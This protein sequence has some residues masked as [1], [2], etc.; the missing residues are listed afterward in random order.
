MEFK[1]LGLPKEILKAVT[2]LGFESPSE[3]QEKA[4]P[5]LSE[6]KQD[7]VGLAQTGTG[8][9]A[10]F[11]LPLIQH[12]NFDDRTTQALIICP[13][14][15]LCMQITRDLDSFAIYQNNPN[16]TSVYG[17]ANI[18]DQIRKLKK[19]AQII[20]ATPGRLLDLINRKAVKLKSVERLVLDEADEMLNMGFKEDI[21]AI[22]DQT[23]AAKRVWLFSATM[24]KAVKRIAKNYMHDPVEIVVGEQNSVAANIEHRYYMMKE[25]DRYHAI[26]RI[27]DFYPEIYGL[28]FCRTRRE[29]GQIADKL[30]KEGY[31]V[32]ALHGDLSQGQRDAAMKKFREKTVKVLVATDVAARGIDVK[33]ISHVIHYN[34]PD[35]IENYTHRSGRTARAGKSGKS[36]ALVNTRE[37][38]KIK[39]VESLLK[40]QMKQRSIPNSEEICEKQMYAL[41]DRVVSTPVD[42]EAIDLYWPVFYKKLKDLPAEEI[43]LKFISMELNSFLDYYKDS[44]DLNAS[45]ESGGSSRGRERAGGKGRP[46][47]RESGS[48][49]RNLSGSKKKFFISLGEKQNLNKG[50]L[51]RLV[52]SET[53][54]ES[55]HMGRIDIHSRHA[56]FEV[57]EKVSNQILPAIKEGTYEGKSF[58]VTYSQGSEHEKKKGKKKKR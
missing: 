30:E 29:T 21:D 20:V 13:T 10:A 3:I 19:G 24:P 48:F 1:D 18:S 25:R 57:D 16:I 39:Q 34:L 44:G 8:K 37:T 5:I 56:F 47:G 41:M 31:S 40:T 17:G 23:P 28:I 15:E 58:E 11:G 22:L 33:D 6:G 50:A 43:V 32:V 53:G 14:R 42:D 52:C 35:D 46:G 9:T 38:Y 2:K 4:I 12:I 7:F 54:I 36:L 26:K 49:N 27:L 51:L 55:N 45:H